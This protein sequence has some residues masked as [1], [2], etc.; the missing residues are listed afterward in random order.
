LEEKSLLSSSIIPLANEPQ[1]FKLEHEEVPY[2]KSDINEYVCV[3]NKL[4]SIGVDGKEFQMLM[5]PNF[6]KD[7]YVFKKDGTL[8][9]MALLRSKS[10]IYLT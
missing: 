1:Q 2:Y 8:S 6:F 10:C 7:T 4:M 5:A 9:T 3:F